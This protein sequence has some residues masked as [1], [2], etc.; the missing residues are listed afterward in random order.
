MAQQLDHFVFHHSDTVH[1]SDALGVSRVFQLHSEA[2][3]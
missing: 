2:T 3:K 1:L